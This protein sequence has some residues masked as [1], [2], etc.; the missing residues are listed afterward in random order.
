MTLYNTKR[1]LLQ[2]VEKYYKMS[3]QKDLN[4]LNSIT[5]SSKR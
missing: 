1:F 5:I 4:F 3:P 2:S